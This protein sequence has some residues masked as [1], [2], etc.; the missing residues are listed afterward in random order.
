AAEAVARDLGTALYKLETN[1]IDQADYQDNTEARCY[2][3]KRDVYG[4]L[5]GFA[6]QQGLHAVVDGLNLDDLSDRRP[7]R[8]AA[9]EAGVR[10][11]LAETGLSKAEVRALSKV[12]A[13]STWDKPSMAC[14][15]SRIPYGR[16]VTRPALSQIDR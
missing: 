8:K 6:R 3:C 13:L 10:S 14:L 11:P 12:F 7:G 4:A 16:P 15:S 9:V 5:L 2:F 1:E